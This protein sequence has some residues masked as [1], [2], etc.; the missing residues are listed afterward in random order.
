MPPVLILN[1]HSYQAVKARFE[2][3]AA[4]LGFN[5]DD[6]IY[7]DQSLI[8][9]QRFQSKQRPALS[10]PR[11]VLCIPEQVTQQCLKEAAERWPIFQKATAI[12]LHLL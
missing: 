11:P 6:L 8:Q 2:S 3:R 10:Y 12:R 4:E 9:A 7:V 5:I 1:A